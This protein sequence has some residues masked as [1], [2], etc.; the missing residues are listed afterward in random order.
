M[1]EEEKREGNV[2]VGGGD[3]VGWGGG[4]SGLQLNLTSLQHLTEKLK[5][6]VLKE[7]Y[8]REVSLYLIG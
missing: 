1:R 6:L 3:D 7:T 4:L 5:K 8:L 2:F